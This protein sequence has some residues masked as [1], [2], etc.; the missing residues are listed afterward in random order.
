MSFENRLN[1]ALRIV[2]NTPGFEANKQVIRET[3][4]HRRLPFDPFKRFSMSVGKR[5]VWLARDWEI[6]QNT[7]LPANAVDGFAQAANLIHE[8]CHCVQRDAMGTLGFTTRY[9][10]RAGRYAL[11]VEAYRL[12]MKHVMVCYQLTSI[13]QI[14]AY[15]DFFAASLCNDYFLFGYRTQ[16]ETYAD[17]VQGL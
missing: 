10:Q 4:Y 9:A 2:D 13:A 12:Q 11:E 3:D 5:T 15:V 1:Q 17:F 7:F 16:Q 14:Q 8:S 6:W